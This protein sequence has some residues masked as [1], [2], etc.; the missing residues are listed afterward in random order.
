MKIP[1]IHESLRRYSPLEITDQPVA[2][3]AVAVVLQEGHRGLEFLAI[4]RS[5]RAGDPWSGHMALPGGRMEQG[6][7]SLTATAVRE[8]FEEV[9]IDLSIGSTHLGQLDD[10]RAVSRGRPLDLV[11]SPF[12]FALDSPRTPLP[13]PMEVQAAYWIPLHVLVEQDPRRSIEPQAQRFE[14]Q[15]LPAFVHEGNSIWG[16]TY[17]ML[18]SLLDVVQGSGDIG[19]RPHVVL[20]R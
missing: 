6:D 10:L 2:R 14:E 11:I 20:V 15:G 9:G 7:A 13:N 8:T 12:V 1:I 3:A 19:S 5:E 17:R 4:R 16:L 18:T